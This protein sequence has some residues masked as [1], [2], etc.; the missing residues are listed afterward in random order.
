MRYIYLVLLMF[1]LVGCV[2]ED[3]WRA[4]LSQQQSVAATNAQASTAAQIE[5]GQSADSDRRDATALLQALQA[6]QAIVAGQAAIADADSQTAIVAS[7]NETLVLVAD[8]IAEASRTDYTPLYAGMAALVV[9]VVVWLLV[10]RPLSPEQACAPVAG[11]IDWRPTGKPPIIVWQTR[12]AVAWLLPDETVI[13]HRY[14]DG[15][16]LVY[17]P[18]DEMHSKLIGG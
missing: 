1:L 3:P 11:A 7:N 2:G 9:I 12:H 18:G 15:R 4:A 17:L 8:R 14:R 13:L 10:R 6:Q 16:E 5:R